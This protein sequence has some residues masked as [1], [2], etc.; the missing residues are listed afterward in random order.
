MGSRAALFSFVC[1]VC[2]CDGPSASHGVR[3]P[4]GVYAEF[5]SYADVAPELEVLSAR[6]ATLTVAVSE[7]R[8]GDAGLEQLLR[9]A[10]TAAVP[11]R[12]WLV[13]AREDGYWPNETNVATYDAAV[14]RLLSWLAEDDLEADALVFDL[15]PA[16][17]YSEE[18]QA[19]LRTSDVSAI[20]AL[21]R[22]HLDPVAFEAAGVAL[23]ATVD[24]VHAAGL[25]AECVTYP[26][27][28]DDVLDGDHD[29]EDALDIPVGGVAW[30]EIAF[31]VYQTAFAEA[32]GDGAFLGPSLVSSYAAD[33]R[34]HFGDRATIAL[35]LIGHAGIFVPT[36]PVY[37]APDVLEADV[38]AALAEGITRI[39]LYSLDG[40][41]EL[42]GPTPW[43]DATIAVPARPARVAPAA[44]TARSLGAALDAA[45]DTP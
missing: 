42:G 4:L 30:D 38:A 33:A 31:M 21:A 15:E 6:D 23:S 20:I 27:V 35:G 26:Q 28:V 10:E 44:R 17:T 19:T 22:S 1:L 3:V 24:R 45:L 14:V 37:E 32:A 5:L 41:V 29:L 40:M 25:R 12:I 7:D 13:L 43:L 36:G 18:L 9:D 8:I 34:E 11:V 39:E 2:A 16:Y